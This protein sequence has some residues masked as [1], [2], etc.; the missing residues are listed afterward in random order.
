[1]RISACSIL[2]RRRRGDGE[3]RSR[4][5][6]PWLNVHGA[7]SS[8]GY[9]NYERAGP[10]NYRAAEP[11]AGSELSRISREAAPA[12]TQHG[13]R[14]RSGP[15]GLRAIL[16]QGI[17]IAISLGEGGSV[18]STRL[19]RRVTTAWSGETIHREGAFSG[20]GFLPLL[21]ARAWS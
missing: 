2:W 17:R 5:S 4:G 10:S 15:R 3:G 20:S 21:A 19:P 16:S 12:V 8:P 6:K 11:Q 14:L 7:T 1:M 9:L 13:A 18:G